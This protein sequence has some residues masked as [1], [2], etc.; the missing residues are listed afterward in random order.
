MLLRTFCDVEQAVLY[1]VVV[2]EVEARS[3]SA[4]L[5]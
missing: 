3:N 1:V 4:S 2:V 5:R